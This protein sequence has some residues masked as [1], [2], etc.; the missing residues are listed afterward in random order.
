MFLWLECHPANLIIQPVGGSPDAEDFF[1]AYLAAPLIIGL[2]VVWKVWSWFKHPSH[3]PL[4]VAVE[5][6]DIYTG[7]REGQ[8]EH[9]SGQ[10]V[11]AEERQQSIMQMQQEQKKTPGG[12]A[13][14]AVRALF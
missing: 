12:R 7:M 14:S 10:N 2:Y 11:S 3:R 13:L 9:V 4:F 6:I 5:D 1:E 8:L